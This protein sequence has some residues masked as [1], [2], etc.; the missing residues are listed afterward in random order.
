MQRRLGKIT[1]A[2]SLVGLAFGFFLLGILILSNEKSEGAQIA[3]GVVGIALG[4]TFLALAFSYW[5]HESLK[6]REMKSRRFDE[7]Q[8][9]H[10]L[11][12][13]NHAKGKLVVRV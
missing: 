1:T 10:Q 11:M 5:R 7:I 2:S 4:T 13:S 9:A 3:G 6:S 8:A 12:E